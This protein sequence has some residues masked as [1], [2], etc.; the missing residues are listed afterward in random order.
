MYRFVTAVLLL[1]VAPASFVLAQ[2]LA[3]ASTAGASQPKF[4]DASIAQ[5]YAAKC[6]GCGHLYAGETLKGGLL[7]AVGGV[8]LIAAPFALKAKEVEHCYDLTYGFPCAYGAQLNWTPVFTL[9]GVAAATYIYG[10]VD[11]KPS[12]NRMNTRNGFNLALS[13]RVR[14]MITNSDQATQVGLKVGLGR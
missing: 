9:L 1:M 6:P 7:L 12:A 5:S 3:G 4:I 11:A 14:P 13:G 2:A 8:A 10:L